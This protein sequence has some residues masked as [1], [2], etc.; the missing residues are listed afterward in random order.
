[1]ALTRVHHVGMVTGDL[2][3]SRHILVDG[4]GLSVD[5]HRTPLPGGRLGHD[6]TTVLEFPI[7]EM[8]YEV[9]RPNDSESHP[10]HYLASTNGRG[11]ILGFSGNTCDWETV[12]V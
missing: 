2:D 1:M 3:Y 7:G 12:Y 4:F 5:E 11:G 9:A 8:Y 10:A 6:G